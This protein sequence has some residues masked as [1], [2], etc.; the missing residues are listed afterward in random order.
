MESGTVR[1]HQPWTPGLSGTGH[2]S[3]NTSSRVYRRASRKPATALPSFGAG[4]RPII[5]PGSPRQS[6]RLKTRVLGAYNHVMDPRDWPSLSD[7]LALAAKLFGDEGYRRVA[8]WLAEEE[9]RIV[10]PD[11]VRLFT[12][13]ITIP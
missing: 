5:R 6:I 4:M 3:P 9:A 12:D 2:G 11:Y 10:D 7:E 8:T 1:N 13:H